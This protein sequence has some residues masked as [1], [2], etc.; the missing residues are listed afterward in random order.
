MR[1]KVIKPLK[2]SARPNGLGYALQEV[3]KNGSRVVIEEDIFYKP[4]MESLRIHTLFAMTNG[5]EKK[6]SVVVFKDK[7]RFEKEKYF[8]REVVNLDTKNFSE[9]KVKAI[10]YINCLEYLFDD[11]QLLEK[12]ENV[13]S[14]Y[15]SRYNEN[16]DYREM[17]EVGELR[18]LYRSIKNAD[19]EQYQAI[20]SQFDL[21]ASLYAKDVCEEGNF[22]W[23]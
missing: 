10:S 14:E 18:E 13:A 17:L 4:I 8:D 5:T 20:C 21:R 19:W 9:D 23:E 15:F 11:R 7:E 22:A 16:G 12:V 1:K 3:K 2:I 6:Y